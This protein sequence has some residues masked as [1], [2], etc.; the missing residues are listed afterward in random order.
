VAVGPSYYGKNTEDEGGKTGYSSL[1]R[2][3]MKEKGRNR[4]IKRR[5]DQEIFN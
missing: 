2:N 1:R 5:F 3:V 4:Q